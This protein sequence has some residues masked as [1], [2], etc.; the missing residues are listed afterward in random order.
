MFVAK[1][2]GEYAMQDELR[3]LEK[4]VRIIDNVR[5][6]LATHFGQRHLDIA[7]DWP[8]WHEYL[9]WAIQSDATAEE[10]R[11]F[12]AASRGEDIFSIP[13]S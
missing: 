9:V 11:L 4:A 5:S 6:S 12:R 3:E 7:K 1:L 13:P 10:M 2:F 8:D